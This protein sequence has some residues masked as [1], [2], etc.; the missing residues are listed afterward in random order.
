MSKIGEKDSYALS[1]VVP[2][3]FLC[4]ARRRKC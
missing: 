4:F 3:P 2:L 1:C